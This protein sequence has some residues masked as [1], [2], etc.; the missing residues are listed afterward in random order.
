MI[1]QKCVFW[2]KHFVGSLIPLFW[3]SGDVWLG[4]Q[5]QSRYPHLHV[6]FPA[7]DRF[8]RFTSGATPSNLLASS[9][10]AD[11]FL[12]SYF[13]HLQIVNH[14]SKHLETKV[15]DVRRIFKVLHRTIYPEDRC[16]NSNAATTV[17]AEARHH[18]MMIMGQ[19][20]YTALKTNKY[21]TGWNKIEIKLK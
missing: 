5:N 4:F 21:I 9:I 10:A 8:L 20:F 16:L 1:T 14:I 18:L 2:I 12:I 11:P 13:L 15:K 17:L 7:H 3:T 19:E 6:S